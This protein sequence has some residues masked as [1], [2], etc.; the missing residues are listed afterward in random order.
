MWVEPRRYCYP[1]DTIEE[2]RSFAAYL[3]LLPEDAGQRRYPLRAS[4]DGLRWI[5][6]AGAAWRLLPG[7][8]PP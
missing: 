8:F 2:E 1:T 4:Y 7:D 6:L 3:T 5:V